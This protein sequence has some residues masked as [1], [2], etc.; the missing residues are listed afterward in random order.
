MEDKGKKERGR[1]DRDKEQV[2]PKSE[3]KGCPRGQHHP[4]LSL[5]HIV[6]SVTPPAF[7]PQASASQLSFA[8]LPGPQ[9]CPP[10]RKVKPQMFK[11]LAWLIQG[12]G[13]ARDLFLPIVASC[14]CW[15]G[16]S[17]PRTT[18]SARSTLHAMLGNPG[19][20]LFRF[21]TYLLSLWERV[22]TKS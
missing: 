3:D 12:L 22:K 8:D 6:G 2:N 4:Q 16:A 11:H 20:G 21:Q 15:S 14:C 5:P 19:P 17:T 1:R 18:A 13:G 9:H 10:S 7:W